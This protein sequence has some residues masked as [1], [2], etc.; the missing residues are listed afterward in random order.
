MPS[1]DFN[2]YLITDRNNLPAG[3]HLLGRVEAALLGGVRCV[4]LR[5]KDLAPDELLPLAH[6]MRMLTEA[7]GARL[8]INGDLEVARAVDADGVHLGG[9]AV[10][11]A[12]ARRRLGPGKLIGVSTHRVEEIAAAARDGAD[13]VTF[14][15]VWFTASKARYCDPAGL[16]RLREACTEAPLPVFALGGLTPERVDDLRS[17]GCRRAACIGAILH[18]DDPAAAARRFLTALDIPSTP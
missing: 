9:G 7:F 4:Q 17:V 2:L 1:V 18:A 13:F 10:P 14:G 8:L 5:E 12:E 6:E 15:P 16:D 11:A 3:E